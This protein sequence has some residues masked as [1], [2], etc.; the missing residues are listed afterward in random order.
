MK[1]LSLMLITVLLVVCMVCG[2][3]FVL[4]SLAAGKI[5]LYLDLKSE[6]NLFFDTYD[7]D[8]FVDEQEVG[9]V[10]N[11]ARFTKLIDVS[12][13]QH[14]LMFCKASNQSVFATKNINITEDTTFQCDIAHGGSINLKNMKT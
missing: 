8:I 2:H 4:P 5:K 12:T 10:S 9:S 3:L 11:G 1:R 14:E 7:I 6:A 13:G